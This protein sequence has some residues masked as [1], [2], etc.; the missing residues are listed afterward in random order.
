MLL[1]LF[2]LS[3]ALYARVF[4]DSHRGIVMKPLKLRQEGSGAQNIRY[5]AATPES[6]GRTQS[7]PIRYIVHGLYL[8]P[9]GDRRNGCL[10]G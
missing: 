6:N 2:I 7:K 9:F 8:T 5:Q 3:V 4:D 10:K 1:I